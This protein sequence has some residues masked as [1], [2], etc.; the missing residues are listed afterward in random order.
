MNQTPKSIIDHTD[1]K[2][3]RPH[4]SP[5]HKRRKMQQDVIADEYQSS[6]KFPEILPHSTTSL[7]SE[8][9][10]RL[11]IQS[12]EELGFSSSAKALREESGT[13]EESEQ[14]VVFKKNL[15]KGKWDA[16]LEF[17][18]HLQVESTLQRLLLNWNVHKHLYLEF[19]ETSDSI[20]A[21][22]TLRTQ[23]KPLSNE[24]DTHNGDETHYEIFKKLSS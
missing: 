2:S 4:R 5:P 1:Q 11:M 8:D 20:N 19:I 16:V 17:I 3:R 6:S 7:K 15:L 14:I 10:L 23:L 22:K 13:Y 12:M 24:I 18:P 9:V 21:L